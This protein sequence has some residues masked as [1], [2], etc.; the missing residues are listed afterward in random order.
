MVLGKHLRY[1][2]GAIVP[3]A[4]HLDMGVDPAGKPSIQ[5]RLRTAAFRWLVKNIQR[6]NPNV[7]ILPVAREFELQNP[8]LKSVLDRRFP[9]L[10]TRYLKRLA[11]L[12]SQY[13]N[14]LACILSPTA[15]LALP[16][17]PLLHPQLHRSLDLLQSRRDRPLPYFFIG[18]YPKLYAYRHYLA[19]LLVRHTFVAQGPFT[20]PLASYDR[21]LEAVSERIHQLRQAADFVPPDYNRIKHK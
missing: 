12:F 4:V 7:H 11:Q 19:P 20:V 8:R 13:Q 21:A 17:K 9:G 2:A 10:N 18:A 14:G 6:H 3:Y 5:Y 1:I 15:G 16:E